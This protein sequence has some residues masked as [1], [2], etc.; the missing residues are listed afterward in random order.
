MLFS[1][2]CQGKLTFCVTVHLI[3]CNLCRELL[4]IPMAEVRGASTEV[5]LLTRRGKE[6]GHDVFSLYY[7]LIIQIIVSAFITQD[8]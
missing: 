4:Q 2:D 8:H 6:I 1:T 5:A 3:I 7:A